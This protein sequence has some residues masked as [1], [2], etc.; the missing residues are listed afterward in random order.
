MFIKSNLKG[1]ALLVHTLLC[2]FDDKEFRPMFSVCWFP[3]T[4]V[5]LKEF[6]SMALHISQNLLVPQ[7]RLA[8]NILTKAILETASGLKMWQALRQVSD[9]CI[10]DHLT[11]GY[12]KA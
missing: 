5:E 1:M 12:T 7:G 10:V 8:P 11:G 6:K 2:L 9:Y 3:Y 4:M